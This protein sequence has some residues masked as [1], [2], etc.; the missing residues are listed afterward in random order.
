MELSLSGRVL[1]VA[2]NITDFYIDLR[3]YYVRRRL[4]DLAKLLMGRL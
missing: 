3:S 1:S 2:A 4:G